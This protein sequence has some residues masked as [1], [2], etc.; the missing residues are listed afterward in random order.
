MYVNEENAFIY[1]T[2]RQFSKDTE[3]LGRGFQTHIKFN[4]DYRKVWF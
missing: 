3:K 4:I 1:S 2:F